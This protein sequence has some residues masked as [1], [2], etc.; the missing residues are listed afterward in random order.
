MNCHSSVTKIFVMWYTH[1]KRVTMIR[2]FSNTIKLNICGYHD[3]MACLGPW[4]LPTNMRKHRMIASDSK[5]IITV[6]HDTF[7]QNFIFLYMYTNR[8]F[9]N[10]V[11][12]LCIVLLYCYI[13]SLWP[14]FM[15]MFN[16]QS[17][18][19]VSKSII[20]PLCLYRP[21]WRKPN[22]CT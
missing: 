14:T 20:Y 4:R 9:S 7:S 12:A 15:T 10:E 5:S 17:H 19:P 6:L 22:S 11:V 8:V 21:C 13:T 3:I 18:K 16:V 2:C 1:R